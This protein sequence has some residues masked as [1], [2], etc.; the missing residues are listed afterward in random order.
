MFTRISNIDLKNAY[1]KTNLCSPT[2]LCY[3]LSSKSYYFRAFAMQFASG[4]IGET[5]LFHNDPSM[6][7]TKFMLCQNDSAGS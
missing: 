7:I 2:L 1:V 3:E 4:L 6:K 5:K